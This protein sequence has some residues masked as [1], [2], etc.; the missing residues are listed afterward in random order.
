MQFVLQ[1]HNFFSHS[2]HNM[3]LCT[4]CKAEFG[5]GSE[6]IEH[7][8]ARDNLR[9]PYCCAFFINSCS[10]GMH[11]MSRHPEY[12]PFQNTKNVRI[13]LTEDD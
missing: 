8:K 11:I 7:E 3:P 4:W 12:V 2:S 6:L 5:Q 10:L 1:E 13:K 9:C